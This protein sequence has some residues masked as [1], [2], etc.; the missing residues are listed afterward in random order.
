LL[1]RDEQSAGPSFCEVTQHEITSALTFFF[2][3]FSLAESK[4]M[5]YDIVCVCSSRNRYFSSAKATT[6]PT[7]S[8]S[9]L[10]RFLRS[11]ALEERESKLAKAVTEVRRTTRKMRD[12]CFFCAPRHRV[13]R[14][15][16]NCRRR[17]AVAERRD[18]QR[19]ETFSNIWRTHAICKNVYDQYTCSHVDSLAHT[20]KL[21]KVL[22]KRFNYYCYTT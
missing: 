18:V 13:T 3:F 21:P 14:R 22:R 6:A 10:M 16:R 4:E 7:E 19:R 1:R 8:H 15:L 20:E 17:F 5:Y 12:F 2:F 9:G 11:F